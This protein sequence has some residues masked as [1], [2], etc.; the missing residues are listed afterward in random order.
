MAKPLTIY[1]PFE[2]NTKE[3]F[4]AHVPKEEDFLLCH[5]CGWTVYHQ[6]H[7]WYV[8]RV[9]CMCNGARGIWFIGDDYVLKERAILEYGR[10]SVMGPDVSISKFLTEN[11]TVPVVKFLHHWKDSQSHFSMAERVPGDSL[12]QAGD[13]MSKDGIR[14][15]AKEVVEYLIEVRKFTSPKIGAPDGSNIR[16]RVIGSDQRIQFVT[17]DVEKWWTRAK[18]RLSKEQI[19]QW[20]D[21]IKD[22]YPVK[23]PYVLTH[24]DLDASNIMVKDGHVTGIIDWEAGGY[25][26]EWWE[27]VATSMQLPPLWSY[28][29]EEE[30]KLQ[31][32]PWP[33]KEV[34]FARTFKNFFKDYYPSQIEPEKFY[35]QDAYIQC[36]NYRRYLKE[37]RDGFESTVRQR[38]RRKKQAAEEESAALAALKKL[39]LDEKEKVKD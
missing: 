10:A 33:E 3:E 8:S 21:V 28:C 19:E 31:I 17:D 1:E 18:L 5:N 29:F 30:W 12:M 27:P 22:E 37:S 39:S 2:G 9:K 25:L 20:E 13:S 32:G 16:D 11:S 6:V 7:Y 34:Q 26:P 23:G 14:L 38:E 4:D 24:G 36:P 35:D 15:I